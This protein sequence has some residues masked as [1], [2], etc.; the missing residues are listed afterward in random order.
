MTDPQ[1][2]VNLHFI[3]YIFN[4]KFMYTFYYLMIFKVSDFKEIILV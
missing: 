2:Y 1:F 4:A 3:F